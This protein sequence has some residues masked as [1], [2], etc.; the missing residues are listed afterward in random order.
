M[1]IYIYMYIIM[2]MSLYVAIL[3]NDEAPPSSAFRVY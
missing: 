3:D 2:C 1:C